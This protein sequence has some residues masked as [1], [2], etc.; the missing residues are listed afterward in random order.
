MKRGYFQ[1]S[2]HIKDVGP[3]QEMSETSCRNIKKKMKG[4][5]G[6]RKEKQNFQLLRFPIR[7]WGYGYFASTK[8]SWAQTY[9]LKSFY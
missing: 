7:V 6:S 4:K 5:V 2:H 8:F 9:E 3:T 1:K